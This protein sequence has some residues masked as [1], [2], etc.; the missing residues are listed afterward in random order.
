M[1]LY[2]VIIGD[3]IK[4][5]ELN[6]RGEVQEKLKKTLK[7]INESFKDFI[8]VNFSIV[9]GDEF[10]GLLKNPEKSYE[11]IK[12]IQKEMYPVKFRF[13]I[14][15]GGISTPIYEQIGEMDGE[16][17]VRAREAIERA[18][19]SNQS[20]IYLTPCESLNSCLNTILMLIDTLKSFW[21][22]KH[23]RRVFL[24][25]E[26]KSYERV[27][28]IEKISKQMIYKTFKKIKYEKI[29]AAEEKLNELLSS[30][31]DWYV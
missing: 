2:T 11:I 16:C 9:L 12:K 3:I 29:K 15:I 25:E 6:E 7:V 20:I 28:K 22:D 31:K 27:A 14:G 8:M 4:S 21:K 30:L 24:Y 13:G 19:R 18:K 17:F 23:Y 26:L 1:N 10:Q 5:R